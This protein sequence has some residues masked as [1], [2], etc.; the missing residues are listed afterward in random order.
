MYSNVDGQNQL[1]KKYREEVMVLTVGEFSKRSFKIQNAI[2]DRMSADRHVRIALVPFCCVPYINGTTYLEGDQTTDM[3]KR[4][5]P[6]KT[7][8]SFVQMSSSKNRSDL[9][10]FGIIAIES[11]KNLDR[12]E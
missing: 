9:K 4:S 2:V 3:L 8:L 10:H 7:S 6:R 1:K 11:L 5:Y 12:R